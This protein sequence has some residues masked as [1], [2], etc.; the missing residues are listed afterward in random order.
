MCGVLGGKGGRGQFLSLRKA[1]ISNIIL[2]LGLESFQKLDVDG[3]GEK[4]F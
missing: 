4:A 1:Y 2:L 3:G